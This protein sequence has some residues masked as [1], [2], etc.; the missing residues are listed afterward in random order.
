MKR[1][2]ALLI[3]TLICASVARAGDVKVNAV[4]ILTLTRQTNRQC[5][6]T[7]FAAVTKA[8]V[9]DRVRY[10]VVSFGIVAISVRMPCS[11]LRS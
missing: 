8:N 11:T 2:L 3:G 5:Q 6:D 7:L 10:I 1:R 9:T 4:I